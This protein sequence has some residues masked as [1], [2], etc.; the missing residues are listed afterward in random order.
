[1]SGV[2]PSKAAAVTVAAGRVVT[3]QWSTMSGVTPQ[4]DTVRTIATLDAA[5]TTNV[6]NVGSVPVPA[7]F[8]AAILS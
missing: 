8:D 6:T 1:M 3:Q 4:E 2:A 5:R 7:A